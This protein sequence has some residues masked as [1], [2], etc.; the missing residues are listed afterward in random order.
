MICFKYTF[1]LQDK[2]GLDIEPEVRELRSPPLSVKPKQELGEWNQ[3][4]SDKEARLFKRHW[5]W[6]SRRMEVPATIARLKQRNH[7]RSSNYI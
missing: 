4:R 5:I 6:N 3:P 7:D 1:L 2:F